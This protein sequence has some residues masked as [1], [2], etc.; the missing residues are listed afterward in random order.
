MSDNLP[1]KQPRTAP[2]E[3]RREQLI[4]ATIT[5]I[6]TYGLSGTTLAKVTAEAG[7]S[8][9]LVN[10]HFKSKEALLTATLTH[11]AD[12]HRA[13]WFTRS[14][15][16]DLSAA[17]KLKLIVDA[18]FHAKICNRRKLSVWFAFFGESRPRKAYR[19]LTGPLD[20]ERQIATSRLCAD[21]IAEGGYSGIDSDTVSAMLESLFDGFWLNILMY[22]DRFTRQSAKA[23]VL[24]YLRLCFP[25]HFTRLDAETFA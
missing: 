3:A 22:P 18:Q 5:A 9:G 21:I 16:P 19:E 1:K 7:L 13:L 6:S 15:Q 23:Q 12:E 11:L 20:E 14:S 2:P 25:Q 17:D 24:S 10:F 4:D 8:L